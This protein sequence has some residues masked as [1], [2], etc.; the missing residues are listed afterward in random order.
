[1]R[2]QS[3][4]QVVHDSN[5]PSQNRFVQHGFDGSGTS[6]HELITVSLTVNAVRPYA[7]ELIMP[8]TIN[9]DVS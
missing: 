5:Y 6:M 9:N 1:M 4:I 2:V 7:T 3:T 8:V